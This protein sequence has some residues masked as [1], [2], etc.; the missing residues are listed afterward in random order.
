MESYWHSFIR[1]YSDRM[2]HVSLRVILEAFYYYLNKDA[3]NP[4][5]ADEL[6]GVKK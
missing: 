5:K 4:D 3:P 6:M 1:H 2:A